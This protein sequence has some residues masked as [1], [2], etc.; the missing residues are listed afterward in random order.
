MELYLHDAG[1][2]TKMV[3]TPMHGKILK[4]ISF[5]EPVDGFPLNLV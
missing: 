3:T 4:K 5:P 1:H 2:M